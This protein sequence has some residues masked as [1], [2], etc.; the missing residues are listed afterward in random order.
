MYIVLYVLV[1]PRAKVESYFDPAED[2][3]YSHIISVLVALVKYISLLEQKTLDKILVL[4][5][6]I[7]SNNISKCMLNRVF[8]FLCVLQFLCKFKDFG[9]ARFNL[10]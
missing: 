3:I 6:S 10:F 7:N 4:I 5:A 2:Q 1:S 8:N 9:S